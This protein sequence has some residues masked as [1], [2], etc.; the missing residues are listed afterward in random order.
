VLGGWAIGVGSAFLI[1]LI[2]GRPPFVRDVD[3]ERVEAEPDPLP[4]SA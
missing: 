4:I 2:A 1:H 3:L